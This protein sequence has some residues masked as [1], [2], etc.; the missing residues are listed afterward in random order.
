MSRVMRLLP[1]HLAQR[2]AEL[3]TDKRRR[4]YLTTKYV[5]KLAPVLPG[6]FVK[7]MKRRLAKYS[8]DPVKAVGPGNPRQSLRIR[9][10]QADIRRLSRGA[11]D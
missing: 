9:L 3:R 7:K 11:H 5:L 8:P 1:P 2:L 10:I 4:K 6:S